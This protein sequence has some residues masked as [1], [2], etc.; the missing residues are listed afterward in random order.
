LHSYYFDATYES[1][2]IARVDFAGS[3]PCVVSRENVFG[4]QFHP[5]KSHAN[6][7][8]L[9]KNFIEIV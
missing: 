7:I 4:T 2:V 8:Q 5:E 1:D 6:G 3:I 9:I